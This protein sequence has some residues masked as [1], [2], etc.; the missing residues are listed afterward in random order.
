MCGRGG[1]GLESVPF[2]TDHQRRQQEKSHSTED[3]RTFE[4]GIP[5]SVGVAYL[6][7]KVKVLSGGIARC[8]LCYHL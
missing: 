1:L 7:A 4:P 6:L 5:L 8:L 2:G 3:Y